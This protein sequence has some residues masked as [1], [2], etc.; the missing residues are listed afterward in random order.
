MNFKTLNLCFLLVCACSVAGWSTDYNSL[1]LLDENYWEG[2]TFYKP[3]TLPPI[4][5]RPGSYATQGKKNPFDLKDPKVIEKNVE[6]D[7]ESNLYIITETVE[8]S[9]YRPP[10]YLTPEEY[11]KWRA[12]EEDSSYF[13]ELSKRNQVGQVGGDPVVP[14]QDRISTSLVERLFCGSTIDVRP[15]GN[16]G[17]TFGFDW[18]KIANPILTEQQQE[19]GGF[20]F[21]MNIQLSVVGKIG[22]KLKLSFNYNTQATFDFDRQIKV[23]YLSDTECSEDDIIKKIEAGNVSFPL[24]SSLIQGRQN[25]FGFRTDLQFGRLKMSLI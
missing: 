21:D 6:Y 14:Y 22:Q 12:K 23:E 11:Y 2:P 13:K 19:Q 16:I 9:N 15:Q 18:Q 3:D 4:T 20:D 17:L 8:G 5:D 1:N 7:A 25:L 10:T 24:R